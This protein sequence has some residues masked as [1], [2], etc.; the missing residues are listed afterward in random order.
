MQDSRNI[1]ED[2][3]FSVVDRESTHSVYRSAGV[4]FARIP[5]ACFL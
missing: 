3:F 1:A 5:V 2:E 4:N